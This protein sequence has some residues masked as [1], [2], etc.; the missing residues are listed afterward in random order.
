MVMIILYARQQKRYKMYRMD[1][2]TLGE[3]EGGMMWE[4][5]TDTCI[6]TYMK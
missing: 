5:A 1:F 2:W 4:N 3:G 6:I